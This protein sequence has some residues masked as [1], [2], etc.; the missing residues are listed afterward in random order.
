[1][2]AIFGQKSEWQGKTE[3]Y[4]YFSFVMERASLSKERLLYN[5]HEMKGVTANVGIPT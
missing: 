2:R 4:Q 5:I 1:M 3:G